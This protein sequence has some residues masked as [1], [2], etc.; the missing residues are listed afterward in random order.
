VSRSKHQTFK[1]V[2]GGKSKREI[3]EL[4]DGE[5]PDCLALLKKRQIKRETRAVRQVIKLMAD[6]SRSDDVSG[7]DAS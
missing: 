7:E 6:E 3:Q 4:I 1:S 5:D 2:F